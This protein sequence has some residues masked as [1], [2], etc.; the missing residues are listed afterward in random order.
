MT[1]DKL[2]AQGEDV[3]MS[4]ILGPKRGGHLE[5]SREQR[6]RKIHFQQRGQS[7]AGN[8]HLPL[9]QKRSEEAVHPLFPSVPP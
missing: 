4:E 5:T 3:D 8:C 2:L 1:S 7:L 6:R 9:R